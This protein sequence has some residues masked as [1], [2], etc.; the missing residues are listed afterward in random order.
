[1]LLPNLHMYG[2]PGSSFSMVNPLFHHTPPPGSPGLAAK[3]GPGAGRPPGGP[4][5]VQ[6]SARGGQ[7]SPSAIVWNEISMGG[8]D[9]APVSGPGGSPVMGKGA[10]RADHSGEGPSGPITAA[11]AM[12]HIHAVLLPH[13][14][15]PCSHALYP[16]PYT[17]ALRYC[18]PTSQHI[19]ATALIHIIAI[20]VFHQA[21]ASPLLVCELALI[22]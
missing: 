16:P 2:D 3:L 6:C 13:I 9:G 14:P 19:W 4:S 21:L 8:R 12:R 22:A 20:P 10:Q 15:T 18:C 11:L 7:G 5:R 1:M 17:G